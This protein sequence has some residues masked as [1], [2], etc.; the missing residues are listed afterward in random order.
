MIGKVGLFCTN[1]VLSEVAS[2]QTDFSYSFRD[3]YAERDLAV[4][5]G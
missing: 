1:K 4:Q 3:R 5:D 2:P